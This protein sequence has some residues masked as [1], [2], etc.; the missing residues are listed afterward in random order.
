MATKYVRPFGTPALIDV[1]GP[2]VVYGDGDEEGNNQQFLGVFA[3]PL[4]R[5]ILGLAVHDW[6]GLD[7]RPFAPR[8]ADELPVTQLSAKVYP[9][10]GI[11][12]LASFLA[13][14]PVKVTH[15]RTEYDKYTVTGTG[16]YNEEMRKAL[17]ASGL[18][19]LTDAEKRAL[20]LT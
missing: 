7:I 20:G 19:K 16:E 14:R 18:S 9:I 3:G 8:S 12:D 2:W 13:G 17:A 6:P 15:P 5:V 4:D 11:P 1:V 10:T